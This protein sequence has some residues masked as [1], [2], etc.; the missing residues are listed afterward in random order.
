MLRLAFVAILM[1][2]GTIALFAYGLRAD[3]LAHARTMAFATM[4]TFQLFNVWNARSLNVSILRVGR[5]RR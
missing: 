1:A 5:C 3:G 2:G 4:A